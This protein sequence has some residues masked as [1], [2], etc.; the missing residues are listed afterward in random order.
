[1]LLGVGRRTARMIWQE[2]DLQEMGLRLP[3]VVELTVTH[4]GSRTH[5]LHIARA[6]HP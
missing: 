3:F 4:A 1:M 5:A 2:P 6:Q